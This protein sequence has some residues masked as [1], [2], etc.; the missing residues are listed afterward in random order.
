M[1]KIHLFA[2]FIGLVIFHSCKKEEDPAP[3]YPTTNEAVFS[4]SG[5]S[6]FSATIFDTPISI[7]DDS[8]NLSSTNQW[9]GSPNN[10]F[11]LVQYG[12]Y[13]E[14][15]NVQEDLLLIY[16]GHSYH[17][18]S[19]ILNDRPTNYRPYSF[20]NPFKNSMDFH[21]IFNLNGEQPFFYNDTTSTQQ[22]PNDSY[23][24]LIIE[25]RFNGTWYRSYNNY[26]TNPKNYFETL[27][28]EV[29]QQNA[30]LKSDGSYSQPHG[31]VKIRFDCYLE[32]EAGTATIQLKNGE[33]QGII[34]RL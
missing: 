27:K 32:N 1:K 6:Y 8:T 13:F 21:N 14:F 23:S 22:I 10:N 7:T 25:Y 4:N 24:G 3:I 9:Y 5:K 30:I 28:Y 20:K 19:L 2:L 26:V 17:D 29:L 18:S 16:F 33:F 31:K 11:S 34:N 15:N 12:N